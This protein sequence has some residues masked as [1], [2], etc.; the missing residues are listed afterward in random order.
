MPSHR[1]SHTP[2]PSACPLS[3]RRAK[4]RTGALLDVLEV[5]ETLDAH[6]AERASNFERHWAVLVARVPRGLRS[7]LLDL[8]RHARTPHRRSRGLI[9][10]WDCSITAEPSAATAGLSAADAL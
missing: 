3:I 9:I 5:G 6:D 10:R 2:E 4:A 7:H 8:I 1:A